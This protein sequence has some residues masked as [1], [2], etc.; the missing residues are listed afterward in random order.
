[1]KFKIIITHTMGEKMVE[2]TQEQ[3]VAEA[4][5]IQKG[6]PKTP[7]DL[8]ALAVNLLGRDEFGWAR[9]VLDQAVKQD[10]GDQQLK[11]KIAQKRALS[12]YKDPQLNREQALTLAIA[13]LGETFDLKTTKDQ[14]TLGL[15]GAIHKRMWELDGIR[16]N[17]E[18]SLSYYE[19]G[20]KAGIAHDD[21]YTAINA[22][23][24]HDLLAFLEEKQAQEFGIAASTAAK[25][26][27]DAEKIEQPSL[28]HCLPNSMV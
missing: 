4:K 27:K 9:S 2:N 12:T 11:E 24:V 7:E 14:E 6:E 10:I 25:H 8:L 13:L 5:A 1:M 3:L 20:F 19:R 15:A 23:F 16:I 26:R 22:A 18:L 17:L 21:G 28:N